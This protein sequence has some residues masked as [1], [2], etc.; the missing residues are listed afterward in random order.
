MKSIVGHFSIGF[1]I[2]A[3]N[4]YVICYFL[5]SK[6]CYS[7]CFEIFMV[8]YVK[9]DIATVIFIDFSVQFCYILL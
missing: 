3:R 4:G 2:Y 5:Y 8:I 1:P 7:N 9:H 6:F